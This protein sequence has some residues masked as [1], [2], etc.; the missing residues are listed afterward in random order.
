MDVA[1]GLFALAGV[2]LAAAFGE[3]RAW[4]E[5]RTQRSQD[6][7][8]LRRE[9]YARALSEIEVVASATARW[10]R[11]GEESSGAWKALTTA[12]G[13]MN[14]VALIAV[15]KATVEKMAAVLRV[16]RTTLESGER[17]LPKPRDERR[18]LVLAFRRDLGL[19]N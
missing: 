10:A 7:Y 19:A 16:Y 6:L 15:G 2:A 9:T 13:T 1:S 4:R 12:Y 8:Q 17:N 14:E 5:G 18:E 3:V 11:E